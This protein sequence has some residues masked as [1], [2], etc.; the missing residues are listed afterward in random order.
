MKAK[1]IH[2]ALN[3]V[4]IISF[5]I[6]SLSS[7]VLN[8]TNHIVEFGGTLGNNY[9]PEELSVEVGDTVTWE[10]NF[11]N[12]PL[13]STSVPPG[14]ASFQKN[15]GTSFSYP[16]QIAGTYIY[17]CDFHVSLGMTGSFSATVSSVE[18]NGLSV[19]PDIFRLEQNYPNPFNPSTTI[20]YQLP[21]SSEIELSV[22]NLLGMKIETLVSER[23]SAGLHQV[24]WNAGENA[25]GVYYYS[26]HA[27][28]FQSVKMMVL[29]K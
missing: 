7:T 11:S 22:Y 1:I 25:S 16:V 19:Q 23:Q 13:S 6:I 9:S 15:S 24:Q 21:V 17:E 2:L 4:L 8:A 29:L 27:G 5:F 28:E 18:G 14:A 26:L 3:P 10:G 12:H 20:R